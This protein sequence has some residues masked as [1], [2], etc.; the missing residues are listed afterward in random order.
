MF[1]KRNKNKTWSNHLGSMLK[2]NESIVDSLYPESCLQIWV[3]PEGGVGTLR[4]SGRHEHL[5]LLC[6]WD[7]V[8]LELYYSQFCRSQ[9]QNK[10]I[11][12][13]Y[14]VW[15]SYLIVL[16]AYSR[17][18]NVGSLMVV[19]RESNE[20]MKPKWPGYKTSALTSGRYLSSTI[21]KFC[22]T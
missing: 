2:N 4:H 1:Y 20:W 12:L 15:V 6:C 14:F 16:K 22:F 11:F 10:N 8:S 17:F 3:Y 21:I 13:F 18:C 5:C 19:L 9:C 7:I